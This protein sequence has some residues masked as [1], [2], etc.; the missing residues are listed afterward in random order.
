MGRKEKAHSRRLGRGSERAK[1]NDDDNRGCA[2]KNSTVQDAEHG[3][4]C[5]CNECLFEGPGS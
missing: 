1:H 5:S 4:D 3:A 2:M